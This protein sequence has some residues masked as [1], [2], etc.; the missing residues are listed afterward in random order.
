MG[1]HIQEIEQGDPMYADALLSLLSLTL[2]LTAFYGPW[3]AVCTDW[4]RHVIF[5]NRDKIFDMAAEN[6]TLIQRNIR[7][8]GHPYNFLLDICILLLHLAS[9]CICSSALAKRVVR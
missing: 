8:F 1:K 6:L 9:W 7:T 2:F 3:Q 4:G 5:E